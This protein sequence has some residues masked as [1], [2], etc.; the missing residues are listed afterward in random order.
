M[1]KK[2]REVMKQGKVITSKR[3]GN[4]AVVQVQLAD[5]ATSRTVRVHAMSNDCSAIKAAL[6][7]R[8]KASL[9]FEIGS[10]LNNG[11]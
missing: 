7:Q 4:T 10:G 11:R 5:E 1:T 2:D 8:S 9:A 6:A 3:E